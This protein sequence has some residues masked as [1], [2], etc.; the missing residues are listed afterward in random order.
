MRGERFRGPK[1]GISFPSTKISTGV[2]WALDPIHQSTIT[3]SSGQDRC[4]IDQELRRTL[5]DLGALKSGLKHN[6][7]SGS[8]LS[9]EDFGR[10]FLHKRCTLRSKCRLKRQS[11][12]IVLESNTGCAATKKRPKPI[13]KCKKYSL[14]VSSGG[15]GRSFRAR[16]GNRLFRRACHAILEA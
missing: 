7:L 9:S 4:S 16:K 10:K 1:T 13:E 5:I 3:I 15:P 6:K 14:L 8:D 12:T 2:G 11:C